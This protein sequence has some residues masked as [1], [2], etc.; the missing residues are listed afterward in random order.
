MDDQRADLEQGNALLQACAG[1]DRQAFHRLYLNEAPRMLAVA[2]RFTGDASLAED[3]LQ[4]TFVQVWKHAHRFDCERGSARTWLF[5]L[6][7][8]RLIN[9]HH[10]ARREAFEP[11]P[12]DHWADDGG[13]TPE[14]CY[15]EEDQRHRLIDCLQTLRLERRRPIL[16]AYY[17]GFTYEQIAERLSVPLGTIKSRVRSGL[18][19][20]QE[21]LRL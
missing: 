14:Q 1:G 19:G 8:Y 3:A 6:L 7:R 15:V 13:S 20:L 9:Q 5:G 12:G 2:R 10:R 16:M 21:C 17:Q 4:E 11:L 18:K